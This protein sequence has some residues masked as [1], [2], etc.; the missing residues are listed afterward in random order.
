MTTFR[1][2]RATRPPEP[3]GPRTMRKVPRAL[4]SSDR[5]RQRAHNH[6]R[7]AA[8][9]PSAKL[10]ILLL[11]ALAASA[12]LASACSDEGT[13]V[14]KGG[15]AVDG[16]A[17]L[18]P[19]ES[20][21]PALIAPG[22]RKD[23]TSSPVV[24]DRERGGVWTAN[25]DVGTVSYVD[26]DARAVV[27]EIAI[28]KDIRSVALSPDARWIAAVDRDGASV[29]LLDA[30]SR[31]VRRSIA[32]GTHPRAAVWDSANPRW[33]YVA[34]EDDGAV[35]I[36]DR[37]A[38]AVL[39]TI[40][41]GRL[42][43]G[44]AVSRQRRELYVTHR[45]DAR[46]SIV[47]LA[48]RAVAV[49]V[50]LADQ[51][52]DPDA[53]R[54]QGRPFAF[55]SLAWAPDGNVAWLPHE[56]LAGTHPIQF[57]KTLFP[58]FSVVDLGDAQA[59]VATDPQDPNGAIAGR[60]LLFDAL[61]VL[62]GGGNTEI[63]SQPCAAA[64]HPK[65]LV[66]YA[67]ACASEDLLVFDVASGIAIDL[68]RNLPGDH[69]VGLALDDTGQ[70][71]WVL[72]DQSKTLQM[73][74]LRGGTPV[75]RV[76]L[77][78]DPLVVAKDTVARDT[79]EGQK[80]FFRANSS[81]GPVAATGNNW[82][83]CG[84]CHLD[85]FVSTNAFFFEALRPA[86]PKL[87]AQIG[88]VGMKDLF[89]TSS[90]PSDS[91]FS[92]HDI[93]IAMRDQGGLAP[94]RTGA[95]REGELDPDKPSA[96][97]LKAAKWIASA[98]ARDLPIGPSWLLLPGD[99]PNADFD[100]EWC[101]K[102]H[103]AEYAAWKLSVHA[104]AG[105]DP[106]VSFGVGVEQKA[107]GPQYSKL[108]SGCHDPVSARLGDTT[109][110]SKRGI[111]CLGC[112]DVERLIDAGGNADFEARAHDWT[113]DHKTWG[114]ASL[115][116]LR[117]PTFCGSC[118]EQF[119]PGSALVAIDTL[120]EFR[121]SPYPANGTVCVDCHAPKDANGV[122]D[123]RMVGGNVYMGKKFGDAQLV[124]DQTLKMRSA[125]TLRAT[126]VGSGV[127][128]YV[129]NRGAGHSF[130]TGVSDVR[131]PWIEV[132]AVDAQGSV[133]AHFGGPDANGLILPGS[134]RFGL[135]I[136]K[137][138][139]TL[140]FQHELSE[141]TRLP[142]ELRVRPQTTETVMIPTPSAMPAGAVRFEAVL[143]YRNV[144]TTYFRAATGDATGSAPQTELVRVKV[145][146]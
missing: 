125:I 44:L 77:A 50:P 99:K 65:G 132:Q 43:S 81:K 63:V 97:A 48:R 130:P 94:D 107:R 138:D 139:G 145:D 98:I 102:C 143:Y 108:C 51:P 32:V 111:T 105:E 114:L 112:H 46:V 72:A 49:E 73:I 119:V 61:N 104:H 64:F 4:S 109:M 14:G 93:L 84:G 23:D 100:G 74:D 78:G 113:K 68:V 134:A 37:T 25:G 27:S 120:N 80:L 33:L 117:K 110:T 133:V 47:D 35:A 53:T 34:V 141:T 1:A 13:A 62:D 8:I 45:I 123:H 21:P 83:S 9:V 20:A 69:P 24:F 5:A 71:A 142:F 126:K 7:F 103:Q 95:H 2:R 39:T 56:L 129:K 146:P 58:A 144:R 3:S 22:K 91:I 118:H 36:I 26:V 87:D 59:E 124:Q 101:G 16:G 88:H 31:T 116:R 92:P 54:P 10:T 127:L 55:E 79:R 128:V 75:N 17:P 11:G 12:T 85:G 28:G 40:A 96:D 19:L 140:L 122:A 6:E 86:D 60:K 30:E 41:V 70:R 135:D 29:T 106:M 121:A 67:L 131:E 115:D 42:P 89:S 38:G 76:R 136:A 82:M 57:Q 52:A 66:A 18:E 137:A 15:P 90:T